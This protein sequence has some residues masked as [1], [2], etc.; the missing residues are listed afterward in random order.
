MR[1]FHKLGSN[2]YKKK[3]NIKKCKVNYKKIK[4]K[5]LKY[6]KQQKPQK[7]RLNKTKSKKWICKKSF[8][9]KSLNMNNKFRVQ[10]KKIENC[11]I[12]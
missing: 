4:R 9:N 1:K 8:K 12:L 7:K 3:I 10:K 5:L 11:W 2:Y 6:Q